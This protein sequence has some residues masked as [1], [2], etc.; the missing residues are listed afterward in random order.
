MSWGRRI[1]NTPGLLSLDSQRLILRLLADYNEDGQ[2]LLGIVDGMG[3]VWE[4][5]L[6]FFQHYHVSGS[7]ALFTLSMMWITYQILFLHVNVC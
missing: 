6:R 3:G 1:L 7:H 2:R 5:F 4:V